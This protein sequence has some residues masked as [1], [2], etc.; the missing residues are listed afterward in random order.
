MHPFIYP[1][2]DPDPEPPAEPNKVI[3]KE[4]VLEPMERFTIAVDKLAGLEATDVATMIESW[5][6]EA[7]GALN[8][9]SYN[10]VVVERSM[11]FAR[12]NSGDG[13]NT[14]GAT[15]KREY[16]LMAEGYTAEGFDT[17]ILVMN[18]NELPVTVRATYMKPEGDPIVKEYEVK[19]R[20]R[21][22]IP[23]DEIEGLEASEV[24]TKLQVLGTVQGRAAAC[25]YG[26]I[27]ERAMYFQYEGIVGGHCSLGVGE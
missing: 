18:P 1:D 19:G 6:E 8:E 17:W 20:S 4:F 24:S 3:T 12:G 10:P 5:P 14:I 15:E 27:A 16:W 25:E 9:G 26:I 11:Y 21:L 23:V 13:H 7:K 2:P 22:T